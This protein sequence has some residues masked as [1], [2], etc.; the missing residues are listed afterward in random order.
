MDTMNNARY[1]KLIDAELNRILDSENTPGELYIPVR[2]TLENGGKRLRPLL[3]LAA[4]EAF[5][6]SVSAAL[7]AAAAIEIFHNFT[8]LH[9]DVID[10]APLRRGLPSVWKKWGVNQAILSGDIMLVMAYKQLED[11]STEAVACFNKVAREVHEGQQ[12]DILFEKRDSVSMYEYTRMIELKTGV[13]I[14][15]ALRIGAVIGGASAPDQESLYQFGRLL[16]ISFQLED[17]YLDTFG[18]ESEF[19]KRIGGDILENKMTFLRTFCLSGPEADSLRAWDKFSGPDRE[20]IEA[21]KDIFI[22]CGANEALA[23]ECNRFTSLAIENLEACSLPAE[24]KSPLKEI[25][26]SLL[27]RTR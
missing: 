2:Y 16:G 9:D 11:Y 27:S 14:G 5:G 1:T 23:V 20:K 4:C 25:S 26:F 8:L 17:D 22:H 12:M 6:T 21:V 7:P 10:N 13:L 15:A 18:T 3:L 19:G 24:K